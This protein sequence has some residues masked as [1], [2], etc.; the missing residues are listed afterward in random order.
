M[1]NKKKELVDILYK[2]KS[3][4]VEDYEFLIKYRDED[5]SEYAKT[6]SDKARERTYKNKIYI[7]GLIE[8][9]NHCKN[10]CYYCG[11]RKSN[12]KAERYRLN[13]DEILNCCEKGYN[14]GFRTFVLQSG[15]D[16]F[17]DDDKLKDIICSIKKR[18]SDVA[19]TLGLGER[20]FESYKIL[21]DAGADRYLLRHETYDKEHYSFLHPD[22]MSFDNRIKCLHN[23]KEIGYQVGCGFMV[24][25]PH[26]TYKTI[27]K[28][29]KFIEEFS[30]D[31]CGIGPFITHKDTPFASYFSGSVELTCFI[32]SL[33]R[34]MKPNVLLPA[35]TALST[36]DIFGREKGI[37]SGANVIMPNLTPDVHKSKY[38][39]YENKA[40]FGDESADNIEKIKK[41]FE[42][43]GYEIVI[44][45]GDVIS[46]SIQ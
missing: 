35:T 30:P 11:I 46:G 4:P 36:L 45:K 3:L 14:L 38:D 25:S 15:E 32:L 7:R 19:V 41:R 22:F 6:L 40:A 23:L 17:F 21:F 8:I 10:D 24:G 2:E 18:F 33:L 39:I 34:I 5:I 37:M 29:L 31:M 20:S 42:E 27:A 1:T 28:D 43:I 9:S 44:D 12:L 26:Q 16:P 13:K